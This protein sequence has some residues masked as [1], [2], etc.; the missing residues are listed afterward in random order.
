[1]SPRLSTI[2]L[3]IFLVSINALNETR[4]LANDEVWKRVSVPEIWK[5]AAG[6]LYRKGGGHAW[7]RCWVMVPESWGGRELELFSETVDDAREVFVNGRRI[8]GAGSFP[9]EFRSGLGA[10]EWFSVAAGSIRPGEYNLIAIRVYERAAR[11]NFN[12]AAP[13][14]FA[15][16]EAIRLRGSWQARSG[17]DAGWSG[18]FLL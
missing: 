2:P 1:M 6:E 18:I 7:F 9:P 12:V 13:A 11:A 15:G 17:D 8:G 14:V 3:A 16:D 5:N 4:A 10:Q